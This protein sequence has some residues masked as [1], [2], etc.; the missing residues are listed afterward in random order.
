MKRTTFSD[1][2]DT[3][4]SLPL[5]IRKLDFGDLER[6]KF[7]Q[8]GDSSQNPFTRTYEG[9]KP[10]GHSSRVNGLT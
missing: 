9:W 1:D 10:E 5:N 8:E 4:G 3:P 6:L 2:V 7:G